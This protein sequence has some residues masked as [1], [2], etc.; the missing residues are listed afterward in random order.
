MQE[1]KDKWR[2]LIFT[3]GAYGLRTKSFM[4]LNDPVSFNSQCQ[5]W[6]SVDRLFLAG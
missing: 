1:N 2:L 6:P 4:T 3:A 5:K